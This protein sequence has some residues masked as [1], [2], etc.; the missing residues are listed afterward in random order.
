M[1]SDEDQQPGSEDEYQLGDGGEE[2]QLDDG[3]EYQHSDEDQSLDDRHEEQ[4]LD[5]GE[6]DQELGDREEGTMMAVVDSDD[7]TNSRYSLQICSSRKAAGLPRGRIGDI[8]NG[9]CHSG[10]FNGKAV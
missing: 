6:E 9:S 4:Q 7:S 1:L 8:A 10:L 3:D 5:D 2:H